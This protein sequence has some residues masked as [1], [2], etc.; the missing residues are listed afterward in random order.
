MSIWQFAESM[1]QD[2]ASNLLGWI[3]FEEISKLVAA[4]EILRFTWEPFKTE[5]W[6]KGCM[7]ALFVLKV[8]PHVYD[9]FFNSPEGYRAQYAR[10][11]ERGTAANRSLLTL[12][13]SRLLAHE[14]VRQ[15]VAAGEVE[16]EHLKGSLRAL[17]AKLWI[18]EDEA[19]MRHVNAPGNEILYPV[20]AKS[21]I[22]KGQRAPQGTLLDIKGGWLDAAGHERRDDWKAY[23]SED[24]HCTGW[25]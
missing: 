3:N 14:Q 4:G 11:V 24:V 7:R 1:P 13:E 25:T 21:R 20:W 10:S 6:L 19:T 2:R 12:A 18:V 5:R 15:A 8:P 23:R 17:D 16:M 22:D 9:A